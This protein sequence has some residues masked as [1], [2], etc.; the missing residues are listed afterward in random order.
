MQIT[1][2]INF[3]PTPLLSL[4]LVVLSFTSGSTKSGGDAAF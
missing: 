2:E 4:S 3:G 1:A